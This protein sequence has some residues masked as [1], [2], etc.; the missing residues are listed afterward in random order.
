MAVALFPGA[1]RCAGF[2]ARSGV[3]R[4]E[5]VFAVLLAR[6]RIVGGFWDRRGPAHLCRVPSELSPAAGTVRLRRSGRG[7]APYPF[8]CPKGPVVIDETRWTTPR[9]SRS[10]SRHTVHGS[11]VTAT[12]QVR[13][14]PVLVLRIRVPSPLSSPSPCDR[15]PTPTPTPIPTPT[16]T[17]IPTI[18]TPV[19]R[20][21]IRDPRS[22]IG[23]RGSGIRG[24]RSETCGRRS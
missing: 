16:P 6:G 19:Q 10:R 1:T 21:E 15:E 9:R 3:G 18:P 11:R 2:K 8:P 13:V 24:R 17:P 23:D 20:S 5:V 12:V 14:G 22:E 4:T 7:F